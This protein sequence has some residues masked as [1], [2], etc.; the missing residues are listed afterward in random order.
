MCTRCTSPQ[1]DYCG[2]LA[3]HGGQPRVLHPVLTAVSNNEYEVTMANAVRRLTTTHRRGLSP[4][5]EVDFRPLRHRVLVVP[6]LTW[7][8]VLRRG[9]TNI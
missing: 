1:Q 6:H 2:P 5:E 7:V 3:L 8:A 4:E 9:A